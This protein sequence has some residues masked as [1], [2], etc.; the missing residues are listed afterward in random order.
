MEEDDQVVDTHT[1]HEGKVIV[2]EH[3]V[4]VEWTNGTRQWCNANELKVVPQP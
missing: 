3:T 4:L 2:V 1:G